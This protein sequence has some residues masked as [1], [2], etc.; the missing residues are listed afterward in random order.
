[1]VGYDTLE[2]TTYP[3]VVISCNGQAPVQIH[4]KRL[5]AIAFGNRIEGL[6]TRVLEAIRTLDL[7]EEFLYSSDACNRLCEAGLVMELILLPIKNLRE[8]VRWAA[9]DNII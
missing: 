1:V 2:H 5:Q 6:Q 3:P 9:D 8:L 4:E 7:E